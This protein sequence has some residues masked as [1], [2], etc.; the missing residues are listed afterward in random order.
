MLE[1]TKSIIKEIKKLHSRKG[2]EEMQLFISEVERL[3]RESVGVDNLDRTHGDHSI[4]KYIVVSNNYKGK[5]PEL[6]CPVYKAYEKI[7]N[8][9]STTQNSQG[10]MAI[11]RMPSPSLQDER[12]ESR[13][14]GDF[15]VEN[16]LFIL[17]DNIQDPGNVG[18]IIRTCEAAGVSAVILGK[19]CVDLYNPK[20]VRSTMGAIFRL[21]IQ[22]DINL[23]DFIK[24]SKRRTIAM[25]LSDSENFHNLDLS[26]EISIIIGNEANGISAEVL[27]AAEIHAKIPM[28]AGESLNAAVATG[29]VVF[30]WRR[31]LYAI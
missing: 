30:E 3:V 22:T 16:S 25:A 23:V 24:K 19:G 13:Q 18:T 28:A 26:G 21:P 1:I 27:E 6:D 17:C 2:R 31:Q 9:I 29:V 20:V 11:C 8:Q 4:I 7:F 5:I 15:K 10:I 14:S 12:S